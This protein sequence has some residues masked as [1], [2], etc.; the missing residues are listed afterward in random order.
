MKTHYIVSSRSTLY[1]G[2][3]EKC[4]FNQITNYN[5]DSEVT[6]YILYQ[7]ILYF[8]LRN[9]SILYVSLE[10]AYNQIPYS[11]IESVDGKSILGIFVETEVSSNEL[12]IYTISSNSSFKLYQQLQNGFKLSTNLT[13]Q[14]K[15]SKVVS[16]NSK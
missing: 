8:G 11:K 2:Y 1:L 12:R 15:I 16:K 4:I 14:R 9:G 13:I 7:G 5:I 10:H 3:M 6:S